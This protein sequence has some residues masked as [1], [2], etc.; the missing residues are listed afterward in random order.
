MDCS[1]ITGEQPKVEPIKNNKVVKRI[2]KP[3]IKARTLEEFKNWLEGL[4]EFQTDDWIPNCEQ[5]ETIKASIYAIREEEYYDEPQPQPIQQTQLNVQQTQYPT[6]T[7]NL[8]VLPVQQ[9]N[10]NAMMANTVEVDELGR[11]IG[12]VGVGDSF[13]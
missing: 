5:W 6:S 1:N 12:M 11:P 13:V 2:K 4:S 7:S 8:E 3:K 9:P 10:T